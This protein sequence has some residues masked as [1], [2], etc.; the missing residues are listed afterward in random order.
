[1]IKKLVKF[2]NP[3]KNKKIKKNTLIS[4]FWNYHLKTFG[5]VGQFSRHSEEVVVQHRQTFL[6]PCASCLR[7]C[8]ASCVKGLQTAVGS[9]GHDYSV[10][11]VRDGRGA[12]AEVLFSPITRCQTNGAGAVCLCQSCVHMPLLQERHSTKLTVRPAS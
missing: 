4:P 1:M 8:L 6:L 7:Q 3:K 10:S 12:A 2:P 5:L 9:R 11:R